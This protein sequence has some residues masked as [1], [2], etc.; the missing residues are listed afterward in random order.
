MSGGKL[1]IFCCFFTTF[2]STRSHPADLQ[3]NAKP[4]VVIAFLA[5]GLVLERY[6]AVRHFN[7]FLAPLAF[8]GLLYPLLMPVRFE[9][10]GS[11]LLTYP[12]LG[13]HVF[14]TLLGHVGFALSFC[15]AAAY[16]LQS[17]ALKRGRLNRF[18]PAL[19]TASQTVFYAAAAGFFVFTIGLGMGVVWMFGAPGEVLRVLDPKVVLALPTWWLFATYLYLRGVRGRHGSRLK[20]F[21]IAG[22]AIALI[23]YLIVPHQFAT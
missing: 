13:V 3:F 11:I 9:D 19:D 2:K 23:N 21:V 12:W 8:L 18:L 5:A 6:T 16:L 22:F 1:E 20:W 15:G 4:V 14:V 17:R 7:L 10:S